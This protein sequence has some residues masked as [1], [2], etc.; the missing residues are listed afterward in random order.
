[1]TGD[2]KVLLLLLNNELYQSGIIS[3]EQYKKVLMEINRTCKNPI[4]K[5]KQAGL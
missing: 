1:M 4:A 5:S 2:K 3:E